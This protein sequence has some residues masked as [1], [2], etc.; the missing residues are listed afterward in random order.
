M[1]ILF[2]PLVLTLITLG[3]N[4][5]AQDDIKPPSNTNKKQNNTNSYSNNL[6]YGSGVGAS[7]GSITQINLQ[8]YLGYKIFNNFN[9]AAGVTYH[10]IS[11]NTTLI[12]YSQSVYGFNAFARFNVVENIFIHAGYDLLNVLNYTTTPFTRKWLDIYTLGV[13]YSSYISD[14]ISITATY[15]YNFTNSMLNPYPNPNI[16]IGFNVGL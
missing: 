12:N 3:V 14:K 2:Q 7:F 5:F 15:Y 1:N 8:P 13:G 4:T 16:Q 10:Y 11:V 9:I 6:F